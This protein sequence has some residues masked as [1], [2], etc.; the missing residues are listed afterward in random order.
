MDKK[1]RTGVIGLGKM[2][3]FHS[4]LINMIPQAELVAVNDQNQ[5]LSK[6][7]KNAGLDVVFYSDLDR[8][9]EQAHLDAVFICT[10]PATHFPLAQHCVARN[11]DVFIEK[12]LAE[13]YSSAQKML[14]LLIADQEVYRIPHSPSTL[15]I[16]AHARPAVY[17]WAG[18]RPAPTVSPFRL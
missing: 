7:V 9:I 12:P 18:A 1:I 5:K 11:L 8:M 17:L 2:G 4:A 16:R 10:P 15:S 3:I 6:Y 14:D 13:S